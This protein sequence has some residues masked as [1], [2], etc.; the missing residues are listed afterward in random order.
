[1]ATPHV[2]LYLTAFSCEDAGALAG[3][4]APA[5]PCQERIAATVAEV[6]GAFGQCEVALTAPY[7]AGNFA[8]MNVSNSPCLQRASDML[9]NAT[10]RFSQPNQRAPDW[11]YALPEPLRS[12]K[13][14]LVALYGSPNV[15]SQFDPH[16]S[17]A[18]GPDAVSVAAA[19][20]ALP[21]APPSVF[22]GE[23]VALG[24]V[25]PHGTVLQ[26]QVRLQGGGSR[27]GAIGAREIENEEKCG[28][29]TD[30]NSGCQEF[31]HPAAPLGETP[32]GGGAWPW[33]VA[34]PTCHRTVMAR[35]R[36]CVP[37]REPWCLGA[38]T[39]WLQG[40]KTPWQQGVSG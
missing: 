24:S 27:G 23:I 11:V 31:L 9:V 33:F 10:H 6:T 21:T 34:V 17:L 18:W 22:V 38:K 7:A 20:E 25:G 4:S 37:C 2:T 40:V 5:L 15:F 12:E 36:Q 26:G 19:I 35:R 16:L 13:L 3:H 32:C 1:M 39:P 30:V 29:L 14:R 8:M 28:M